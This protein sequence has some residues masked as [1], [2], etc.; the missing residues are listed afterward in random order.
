MIFK[1]LNKQDNLS[2][3]YIQKGKNWNKEK[4]KI[5]KNNCSKQNNYNNPENNKYN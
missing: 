3:N 2:N 1:Q 5:I 4:R